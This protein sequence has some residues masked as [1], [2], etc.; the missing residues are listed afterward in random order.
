VLELQQEQQYE[1]EQARLASPFEPHGL[2]TQQGPAGRDT[3]EE[4][5][6]PTDTDDIFNNTQAKDKPSRALHLKHSASTPAP[7]EA[8]RRKAAGTRVEATKPAA[9]KPSTAK[10]RL[11]AA[12][13]AKAGA[14]STKAAPE[15]GEL[16]ALPPVHRFD[17][18]SYCVSYAYGCPFVL[19]EPLAV[20]L[21][22]PASLFS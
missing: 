7:A 20:H 9:V 15:P 5:T 11:P 17:G 2:D 3:I 22:H 4:P 10:T 13:K 1:K 12:A 21:G 18:G 19:A 8:R 14:R 6:D 16:G